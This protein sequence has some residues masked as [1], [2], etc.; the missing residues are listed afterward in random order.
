MNISEIKNP[1]H[2]VWNV[3]ENGDRQSIPM[4]PET[5]KVINGKIALAEIPDSFFGVEITYGETKLTEIHT[6]DFEAKITPEKFR[7]NYNMG[8]IFLHADMEGK[9]VVVEYHSRGMIMY[10][11][12]RIFT[13]INDGTNEIETLQDVV[14]R[15]KSTLDEIGD[16]QATVDEGKQVKIDLENTMNIINDNNDVLN[17]SI[18]AA[19]SAKISLDEKMVSA[20]NTDVELTNTISQANT[21]NNELKTT[22]S[23]AK[24]KKV[25]LDGYTAVKKTE[26][27]THTTTKEGQLDTYTVEKQNQLETYTNTKEGELDSHTLTKKDELDTHTDLKKSELDDFAQTKENELQNTIDVA[28]SIN[29]TLIGS[30]GTIDNA[31]EIN[32]ILSGSTQEGQNKIHQMDDKIA[33]ADVKI[34]E[35]EAARQ[36]AENTAYAVSVF[37]S[38]DNDKTY[39]PLNKVYYNGSSYVC[40]VESIGNLPTDTNYWQMI[41]MSGKGTV[42]NVSST[43]GDIIIENSWITPTLT[44]N[45]GT[46]PNQIPRLDAHGK[47]HDCVIPNHYREI[48]VVADISSRD[49]ITDR[50]E[51]LRI[52]VQDA[53]L[54]PTVDG[55]WAEY[56]WDGTSWSKTAEVESIDVI[57]EWDKIQNIPDTFVHS[58]GTAFMEKVVTNNAKGLAGKSTDANQ[59]NLAQISSSNEVILGSHLIPMRFHSSNDPI[60]FNGMN[61]YKLWHEGSL[62]PNDFAVNGHNHDNAYVSKDTDSTINANTTWTDNMGAKFGNSG[63][64]AIVADMDTNKIQIDSNSLQIEN[65]ANE[66]IAKFIPAGGA[67][68]YH[69]GTKRIETTADGVNVTGG[70]RNGNFEIRHNSS[71]DC[72]EFVYVG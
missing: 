23:D 13:D 58:T 46:E 56:I 5:Y 12:S 39:Y 29:T 35:T 59:Y 66:P 24:A 72:L 50:Y 21:K 57:L 64:L 9:D 8:L 51:G 17:E 67:E 45:A 36:L 44:L 19:G 53:S 43:N 4:P 22:I 25:E 10:P 15:T 40:I 34:S 71:K 32:T 49:A 63:D 2:I 3:D 70:I 11:A 60:W 33:E 16:T 20:Q 18:S 38:Y 52:H 48:K 31:N 14:N 47:L 37:E 55:G 41:A 65:S 1:L 62:N 69:S 54:D 27:D 26:L 30:G 61:S 7:V 28:N 42:N 6:R 68:L